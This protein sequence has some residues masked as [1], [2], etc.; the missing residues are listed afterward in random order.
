VKKN[1]LITGMPKSGKS[2][3]LKKIIKDIP[4]KIGFV[5]NEVLGE[6]GRVGFE[7]E[8]HSGNKRM[9]AH[10][11]FN[12]PLKVSRYFVDVKN[13]DALIPEV[14]DFKQ[15]N[16][17]YLDEIGQMELYSEDFKKLTLK[18][19]DS[20]NACL[21]TLSEIYQDGFT[22]LIRK[23]DDIVLVEITSENREGKMAFILDL[24]NY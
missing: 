4:N 17:L 3:L 2:T 6:N 19:L 20:K 13:L 5:T 16:F 15:G 18:Y 24:L 11:N 22:D 14:S 8:T 12:T 10:I 9:L 7:I 21:A 1:I 23:R